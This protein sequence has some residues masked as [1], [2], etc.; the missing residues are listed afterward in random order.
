MPY[1]ESRHFLLPNNAIF[2]QS[3]N[4][5]HKHQQ[6]NETYYRFYTTRKTPLPHLRDNTQVSL[7]DS[8][9]NS[10]TVLPP[11]PATTSPQSSGRK[12]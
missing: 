1:H 8:S 11:T 6:T 4:N 3:T 10:I 2:S 5:S 7:L 12:A 9:D